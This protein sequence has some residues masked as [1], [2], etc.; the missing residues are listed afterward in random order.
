M[1]KHVCECK[2]E[3]CQQVREYIKSLEEE[4]ETL[5]IKNNNYYLKFRDGEVNLGSVS[6]YEEFMRYFNN[7][8]KRYADGEFNDIIKKL[9]DRGINIP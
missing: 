8:K 4:K 6:K 5:F 2:C 9:Q 7:I 1:T 3:F